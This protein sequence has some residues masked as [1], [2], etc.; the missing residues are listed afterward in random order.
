MARSRSA[1][2]LKGRMLSVTRIRVLDA[3]PAAIDGQLETLRAQMPQNA[4]GSQGM[5]VVVDSDLDLDLETLIARLRSIGMQPL[6]VSIGPLARRAQAMGLAV[7]SKDSGRA[8]S[9]PPPVEAPQPVAAVRRPTRMIHEPVRSGQ[10]IY[11]EDG[12]LIVLNSVSAGA[13][14]IADGCVH[15]YGRLSG[16]A[17]AGAK[18]D[19]SARIFC[20]KLEAELIAIAGTYAVAEQVHKGPYGR[21]AQAYLINGKLNIEPHLA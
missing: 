19:E 18:G 7:V 21:P 1:L 8:N 10:Q 9:A 11:A 14:V 13:E 6:A 20:R 4:P 17:I 15:I 5:A 3:D 16:R 2:E 12:D